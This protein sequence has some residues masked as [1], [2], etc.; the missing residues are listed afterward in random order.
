MSTRGN[1]PAQGGTPACVTRCDGVR[2]LATDYHPVRLD[3]LADDVAIEGSAM[4]GAV[5]SIVTHIR[6]LCDSQ[7]FN[8]AG[9]YGE[10]G[11]LGDYTAFRGSSQMTV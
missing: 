1:A 7:E 8:F 10:N 6:T 4:N 2:G 11:F 5:R 3:N 9:P